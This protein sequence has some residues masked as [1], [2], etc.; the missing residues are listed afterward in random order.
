[1]KSLIACFLLSFIVTTISL[2]IDTYFINKNTDL[3]QTPLSPLEGPECLHT[4]MR[5]IP[6]PPEVTVCYRR[7]PYQI[8]GFVTGHLSFGVMD[9]D[10]ID[11]HHGL[12]FGTWYSGAWLGYREK[13][14]SFSWINMG[15]GFVKLHSWRHSCFRLNF[16]SGRYAMFENGEK[17]FDDVYERLSEIRKRMNNSINLLTLGCWYVRFKPE[18]YSSY[19]EFTDL[20]MFGRSLTDDEMLK[21][22]S[23]HQRIQGDIIS[24]ED[25]DWILNGTSKSSRKETVDFKKDVCNGSKINFHL[26]PFLQ[27]G[28]SRGLTK[29]CEKLKGKV[30]RYVETRVFF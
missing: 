14:K 19:G 3:R 12:I 24:W 8:R 5:E 27:P 29:T 18:E 22:T 21:I 1:M 17:L 20:Q 25:E 9:S 7:K 6:L 4:K 26:V 10:W 16:E 13:G 28:I 11:F 30:A 23:C 2:E 15:G